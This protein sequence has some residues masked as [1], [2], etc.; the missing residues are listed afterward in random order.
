M[1]HSSSHATGS[2]ASLGRARS[3][4]AVAIAALARDASVEMT[5]HSARDVEACRK[6]LRTGARVYVS[7]IPGQSWAD[8]ILACS[9]V[10]AAGLEPVPHVPAREV[11]DKAAL[12]KLIGQLVVHAKVR[13]LLIIAGDRAAP[14]GEFAQSL[15]V[16][17]SGVLEH[18][19]IREI[20]VAGHPEGH[21]R[22]D[23]AN[24]RR[25]E[26]E[27]IEW[28]ARA[29]IDLTFLTQF[30]FEAEPFLAW[31][32]GIRAMDSHV[33]IAAGLA[34]PARLSTLFK[35][36][37]RCG[38]GASIRALGARPASFAGLVTERGPERVARAIAQA[39]LEGAGPFG[40]HLYS[41][42]G[43]EKTCAW[44]DATAHCPLTLDDSGG[45]SVEEP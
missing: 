26:R 40:M 2:P 33:K 10:R 15:D 35:Y 34:G 19:A 24:L 29:G 5:W 12:E 23:G 41:F 1:N 36:A 25:A 32:G 13:R 43:L 38:A 11:H 21:P 16:M 45:F 20:S 31:A 42:G 7:F 17:R 37:I 8:T 18:H 44:I 14:V 3:A 28:A 9:A 39:N 6:F 27:K 22:I 4:E 30:F